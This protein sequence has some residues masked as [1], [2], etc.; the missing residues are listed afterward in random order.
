MAQ[1]AE[2]LIELQTVHCQTVEFLLTD[3]IYLL[4]EKVRR[5]DFVVNFL[6]SLFLS[7]YHSTCSSTT[8]V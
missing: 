8:I 4:L 1:L 6:V 2:R 7:F 5:Q 3:K